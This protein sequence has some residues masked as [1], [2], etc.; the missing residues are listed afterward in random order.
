[1]KGAKSADEF[2]ENYPQW[3]VGLSLLRNIF[4]SEGLIETIKWGIP[5][6]TTQGKNVAGMACF[7]EY[8]GIWFYQG[9]LLR[10]EPK[11]LYCAQEGKTKALRQWRFSSSQAVT[12]ESDNIRKYVQEAMHN[13]RQGNEI[14][15]EKNQPLEI[16]PELQK[17]FDG[18]ADIEEAFNALSLSK[19]REFS[20]Y[21]SAAKRIETRQARLDKIIPMI[22]RGEG[23]NDIYLK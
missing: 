23:L 3:Q 12:A 4:I 13:A 1:M 2:I 10:D 6:Y 15:P 9:A 17:I 22:L 18:N 21:I 16:P 8:L 11:K 20:K 5:V 14:K 7:K 19:K